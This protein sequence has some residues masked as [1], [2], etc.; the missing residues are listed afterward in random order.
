MRHDA[1]RDLIAT[2]RKRTRRTT[3]RKAVRRDSAAVNAWICDDD[4]LVCWTA[5]L[6]AA[7]DHPQQLLAWQRTV[8][9]QGERLEVYQVMEAPAVAYNRDDHGSIADHLERRSMESG[10]VDLFTFATHGMVPR[11]GSWLKVFARVA[12]FNREGALREAAVD[13]LGDLLRA[14][15]PRDGELA[16]WLMKHVPPLDIVRPA[17]AERPANGHSRGREPLTVRFMLA[18][19][20]WLPWVSGILDDAHEPGVLLDNRTLASRHTPRLNE[21]LAAVHAATR[22]CGG[23]WSLDRTQTRDNALAQVCDDGVLLDVPQPL[24]PAPSP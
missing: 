6:S 10:Q 23:S 21:F 3:G 16:D 19:D 24:T 8:L 18:S 9:E 4:H 5:D 22:A 20:I 1:S 15:R 12:Y 7:R 14:L 17:T 2:V 11:D 13:D